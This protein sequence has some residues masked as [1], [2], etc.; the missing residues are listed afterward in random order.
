M[1]T[2][3]NGARWTSNGSVP[4]GEACASPSASAFGPEPADVAASARHRSN[5]YRWSGTPVMAFPIMLLHDQGRIPHL[6]K[7]A[8]SAQR[9]ESATANCTND[10]GEWVNQRLDAVRSFV[11]QHCMATLYFA[12]VSKAVRAD[13][14]RPLESVFPAKEAG[15]ICWAWCRTH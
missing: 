8:C 1:H 6:T 12:T 11:L 9:R 15:T 7:D 4:R 13:P 14:E 5:A 3:P 2:N 10:A